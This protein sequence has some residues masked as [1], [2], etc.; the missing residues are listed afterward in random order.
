MWPYK[1]C[2]QCGAKLNVTRDIT[3]QCP[4]CDTAHYQNAKPCAG[5]IIQ[6]GN[7]IL[8]AKRGIEPHKGKWDVVGGFMHPG[9][10]PEDCAIREAR[11][12]TGLD[13]TIDKFLAM[14]IDTYGEGGDYTLNIYYLGT[15]D[16]GD[17]VATDDVAELQWFDRD[18]TP[19]MAF[20]HQA[21]LLRRL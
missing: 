1:Y 3:I 14:Y 13:I 20:T 17:P 21:D 15:S 9:E 19:E 8:L 18:K 4:A 7:K 10:H 11:E 5:V 2:P 16:L 6:R 12:E